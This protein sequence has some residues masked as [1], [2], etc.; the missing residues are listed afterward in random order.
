MASSD[1]MQWHT[2]VPSNTLDSGQF[3]TSSYA[4]GV[5]GNSRVGT[6]RN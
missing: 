1:V 2:R 5:F 6:S 4:E 3:S